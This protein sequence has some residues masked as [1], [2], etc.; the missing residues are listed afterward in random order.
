M[1]G[2]VGLEPTT[3]GL[4]VD[5][6]G[7]AT[8]QAYSQNK[9]LSRSWKSLAE[10]VIGNLSASGDSAESPLEELPEV[11]SGFVVSLASGLLPTG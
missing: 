9:N 4:R 5:F 7:P 6:R 2:R 3:I 1:L 11:Y 8:G 10:R